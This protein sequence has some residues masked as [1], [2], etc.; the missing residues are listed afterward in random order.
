MSVWIEKLCRFLLIVSLFLLAV[1]YFQAN[2]LPSPNFYQKNQ[3]IEPKQTKTYKKPF[4]VKAKNQTYKISPLF[5]Y[6]LNGVVVSFSHSDDM[7]NI[8]HK[9]WEDY[10]NIKDLCVVWGDNVH[11]GL[12][13]KLN[14]KNTSWTCWVSTKDSSIWQRFN[15]HEFS[16]NHIIVDDKRLKERILN[17]KTGDQIYLRGYLATYENPSNGFIRR[18]STNRTDTGNG[19]CETIYVD[20]FRI[21]KQANPV[22]QDVFF[23]SKF[24]FVLGLIGSI[25]MMGIAPPKY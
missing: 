12:Y 10:L 20:D 11:T 21:I 5:N 14:F 2:K 15:N 17:V 3:L 8:Y 9:K 18:S 25:I 6:E 7:D 1:S 22:W 13:Q 16:N 24:L 4:L 23:F 19:A